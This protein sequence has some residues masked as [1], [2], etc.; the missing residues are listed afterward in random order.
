MQPDVSY[1]KIVLKIIPK[2]NDDS[3]TLTWSD[4]HVQ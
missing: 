3:F 4:V 1:M 2:E